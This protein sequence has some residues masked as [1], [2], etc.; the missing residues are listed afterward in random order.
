[1]GLTF[2]WS[3]E[4]FWTEFQWLYLVSYETIR[5][6]ETCDLMMSHLPLSSS[7]DEIIRLHVCF[8]PEYPINAH[9]S[10][11]SSLLVE[12]FTLPGIF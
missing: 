2:E 1:M 8:D 7:I 9:I 5:W 12:V 3:M 11:T 10:A 6:I 4:R